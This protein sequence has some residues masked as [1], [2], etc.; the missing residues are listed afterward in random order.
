MTYFIFAGD[1][2]VSLFM[3]VLVLWVSLY[4]SEETNQRAAIIP[5]SDENLAL[6]KENGCNKST[7]GESDYA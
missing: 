5:L 4:A 1:M 3:I 6:P 7:K 2:L